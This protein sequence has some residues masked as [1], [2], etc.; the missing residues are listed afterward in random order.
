MAFGRKN[1][2]AQEEQRNEDAPWVVTA[3]DGQQYVCV[4]QPETDAVSPGMEEPDSVEE[5]LGG[6]FDPKIIDYVRENYSKPA[7]HESDS[8][9][10]PVSDLEDYFVHNFKLPPQPYEAA[11]QAAKEAIAELEELKQPVP[12]EAVKRAQQRKDL[13]AGKPLEE[14]RWLKHKAYHRAKQQLQAA[15]A[16]EEDPSVREAYL[17]SKG[18][19]LDVVPAEV[20]DMAPA[21]YIRRQGQVPGL[22]QAGGHAQSP[23]ALTKEEI[24]RLWQLPLGDGADD[25]AEESQWAEGW[26]TTSYDQ[27]PEVLATLAQL[28]STPQQDRDHD[29][30]QAHSAPPDLQEDYDR[31][32]AAAAAY[33][34]WAGKQQQLQPYQYTPQHQERLRRQQQVAQYRRYRQAAFWLSFAV[35]A[36]ASAVRW[37][38]KKAK[39]K[40]TPASM[41]PSSSRAEVAST[42]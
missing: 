21:D 35:A 31:A 28:F 39:G 19:P 8:S 9:L 11:Q 1:K 37:L 30:D 25:G 7:W 42:T 13:V 38:R 10:D 22:D 14:V 23:L 5:A 3:Q 17:A 36:G 24:Q 18:A 12:P 32:V 27:H 34:A 26:N 16:A 20:I 41:T 2:S 15:K 6:Q 33:A 40:Q 4:E 29:R